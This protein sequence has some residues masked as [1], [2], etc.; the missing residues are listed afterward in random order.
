MKKYLIFAFLAAFCA[1]IYLWV[2][3]DYLKEEKSR[4][5]A[6][7]EVSRSELLYERTAKGELIA[8]VGAL[9]LDNAEL[10]H[11]FR[12]VNQTLKDIN[13]KLRHME[14]YSATSTETT[15]NFHTAFRDSVIRDTVQIEKLEYRTEWVDL[16]IFKAGD[17]AEVS[18]QTRDSLIQVVHW[19]RTRGFWFVRWGRKR[20]TQTI[21]SS[22]PDSKITYSELILP[23]KR[24]RR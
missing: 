16:E 18:L 2:R 20:F 22:N 4:Y 13:V 11:G 7:F 19:E 14:S 1:I 9:E 17:L 3:A 12:E 24:K 6:N 21:K 15:Y 5:K 10:R 8:R 23:R